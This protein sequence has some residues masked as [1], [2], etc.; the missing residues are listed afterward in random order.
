MSNLENNSSGAT[1]AATPLAAEAKVSN[2]VRCQVAFFI[3]RTISDFF[4]CLHLTKVDIFAAT[5]WQQR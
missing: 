2:R 1:V 3:S 4:L 5:H